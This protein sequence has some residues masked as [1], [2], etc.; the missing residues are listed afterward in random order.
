MSS[1]SR[2]V[3]R[4]VV[5][6][7][8]VF[9]SFSRKSSPRFGLPFAGLV[10]L[11]TLLLPA[12]ARAQT[13]YS[14]SD[15]I[16]TPATL[17]DTLNKANI[18]PSTITVPSSVTGTVSKIEVQL[19]GMLSNGTGNYGSVQNTEIMLEAPNGAQFE[20]MGG[21][22]DSYDEGSHSVTYCDDNPSNT[23]PTGTCGL[24]GVNI[25]IGAGAGFSAMPSNGSLQQ[26]GTADYLPSSYWAGEP[27]G[28][29]NVGFVDVN[30]P[31]TD[32]GATLA[33]VFES[34]GGVTA[35]GA[36][37]LYMIDYLG[38]PVE[39][40]GWDLILTLNASEVGT[41]TTVTSNL[42]PA[43]TAS[44]NNSVTFTA[45][46]TSG[47]NPVTSGTVAF[48]ANGSSTPITG[49]TAQTVNGSG[50]ATCGT[51]LTAGSLSQ[52][53]VSTL[54]AWPTVCQ[55][56][57]SITATYS[58]SG[59]YSGSTS[60]GFTQ[61]VTVHPT[62]STNTW[63]NGSA[64][65]DPENS[66]S[67]L[68]YPSI[69]SVSG[70]ESGQTVANVTVELE[71]VVGPIQGIA[72][73]FLLVAPGGA[74]NLDFFEQ[75]F[76]QDK[77]I[78]A[79]GV[80]LTFADSAS[81]YVPD[82]EPASGTY[83]PS[84]DNNVENPDTFPQSPAPSADASVPQVPTTINFADPR[85]G[86]SKVDFGE[87]FNGAPV[88]G[89]WSLYS[90]A[91]ESLA[92]DAGWCIT[93]TLNTGT[94][95][96]TTVTSSKNPATTGQSVT[97]TATVKSGGSPV[98]SGG[99]VTFT[100]TTTTT[101]VALGSG[102]LNGSGVA[103]Y[104]SST[105]SEG[106]HQITASYGG[107][108]SDNASYGSLW[109][110]L[111][112]AT[113][114]TAVNSNTWKFCNTGQVELPAYASGPF[115]PN[116]SNIFV[117]NLPGTL[118]SMSL[119]LN[120]FSLPAVAVALTESLIEGPTGA[121]LDF[122][123]NTGGSGEEVATLGT[124]VFADGN[125]SVPD[126]DTNIGPASSGGTISYEP[127]AYA[128]FGGGPDTFVSSSSGFYN[129]P[130]SFYSAQPIGSPAYTFNTGT[131]NAF[132]GAIPVGTWS[133]FFDHRN[134][135]EA[136]ASGAAGGWCL[137]FTENPATVTA[138]TEGTDTY[139]QGQQGA[140]FTVNIKNTGS[141]PTGDPVGNNPLTVTDTLNSDFT[142]SSASGSG[143]TC[144]A[145]PPVKCTN[146][147]AIAAG[148]SY[149]ALV[150][151]VNV[152]G[153]AT[154]GQ[155]SNAFS[156]T[157]GAGVTATTSNTDTVTIL[158]APVLSVLKTHSGTFLQGSTAQWDISVSN[159]SGSAPTAGT[160]TVTDTLPGSYT[161]ASY[162]STGSSWTCTGTGTSSVSCTSST[163]ISGGGSSLITLTVN[164][165]ANSPTSVTNT[166]LTWGG[167]DLT[168][169]SSGSAAS[170]SDTNVPVVQKPASVTINNSGSP[171]TAPISTAF[172]IPLSVT[173]KDAAGVAIPGV[174]V[175][176]MAPSLTG[177]SGTF[178]NSGISITPAATNAS[179]VT[180]AGTFTADGTAGSYTVTATA[181]PA[182]AANFSL[183]NYVLP[184][185]SKAFGTSPIIVGG[186][187]TL[188]FTISNPA[189]NPTLHNLSFSDPF[190]SGIAVASSPN[191]SSSCGG[192]WSPSGGA[193]S[194]S[195][196]GGT[197]AG[198]GTCTI[199]L[200][201]TGTSATT[202]AVT[203]LTGDLSSTETGTTSL[204][205]SAQ[206]TVNPAQYQ[207]SLIVSPAGEGTA[208]PN[209]TN[210]TGLAA[211]NYLPGASV[212]LTANPATGYVFSSWSGSADLSSTTANPTMLTMNTN[213]T[214]TAKFTGG[215]TSLQMTASGKSGT[216]RGSR[217]WSYTVTD[218]GSGA[219]VAA[220][221]SSF[222]L[223]QVGGA[224]CTPVVS[225]TFP[226]SL[227]TLAPGATAPASV[228]IN[229][230]GCAS[231]A[232]FN[233]TAVLSANSGAT[234]VTVSQSNQFQ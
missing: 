1:N 115:T 201:V 4:A 234:S 7:C 141:G 63:C 73:Q 184:T 132:E 65:Y 155:V 173:V 91:S 171:Q 81:G 168:H 121:A 39:I 185:F 68:A 175:S 41:T 19:N 229:F 150:L 210:S 93:F 53:S 101:P 83:L 157:G 15:V 120:S 105:L 103:T 88:N 27:Y 62:Q 165:A 43:Y 189:G 76:I 44:P 108:E 11:A 119:T 159:K 196:S 197:L 145:G 179:G 114:V 54:P 177:A 31:Q 50:Q 75:G 151:S 42:Q 36:W 169:T 14:S 74:Y 152:L 220:Q 209:P 5:S 127:T 58:G 79:P 160:I 13:T 161:L 126:S 130:G 99:T 6:P 200:S 133:L 162:T 35:A 178:S 122:F 33:S 212:Q 64:F 94:A 46:V 109:Q 38:D 149:P 84:D 87:A 148:A 116:P 138:T 205:A 194:V 78:S 215:P 56:N 137:N 140:T 98:T 142:Y 164:V 20:L 187:T 117:T 89:D 135:G 24:Q 221:M 204:T 213:E 216:E 23:L 28:W 100:D 21:V 112:D 219:A 17:N 29:N 202:G 32:G 55:G 231:S 90:V 174:G 176:F 52:C 22:G 118:N 113:T 180:S 82:T 72:G 30:Y 233:M 124:Y 106:D 25:L 181:S 191:A 86:T 97:I 125:S 203:N 136:S 57:N 70:Y 92:V 218:A 111:D 12:T 77:V 182:P 198:G 107:T 80:T 128:F 156:V 67:P 192:T 167:G 214:I 95:T 166:A 85:G 18:Y 195:F 224:A 143:W 2:R 102:T 193:T 227:G 123:S 188:T 16:K 146:D 230:T 45:T 59:S 66:V 9:G 154:P 225:T 163:A 183:T 60:G 199:S 26:T 110:R 71:Q 48:Y 37:K 153:T 104:T 190:P 40:N 47:G 158:P 51:T 147:S 144:V 134:G 96:T 8:T 170:G 129:V 69:I 207:L 131:H 222:S 49:C 186:N 206:I 208:S 172:A 211:G 61:V 226:L 34:S 223:K 228:T 139:V 232:R 3:C 10:V 217:T